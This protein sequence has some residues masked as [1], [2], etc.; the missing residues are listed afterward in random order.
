MSMKGNAEIYEGLRLEDRRIYAS[1]L[2]SSVIEKLPEHKQ[3]SKGTGTFTAKAIPSPNR[4]GSSNSAYP[5]VAAWPGTLNEKTGGTNLIPLRFDQQYGGASGGGFGA[6]PTTLGVFGLQVVPALLI[7]GRYD[8]NVFFTPAIQGVRREDYTTVV[9][10]QL[11]V[12][13]NGRLVSTTVNAGVIGEYFT[14][15]PGL[16][17]VGFNGVVGLDFDNLVRRWVHGASLYFRNFTYYTPAPPSFLTGGSRAYNPL[18]EQDPAGPLTPEDTYIRGFQLQRV[19]TLTNQ[20]TIGGLYPISS[21]TNLIAGYSFAFINFGRQYQSTYAPSLFD[22]VQH[23]GRLGLSERL[24]GRDT[25]TGQY[26]YSHGTFSGGGT[27]DYE[28]H[29]GSVSWTRSYSQSLRSTITGG[30]TLVTQEFSGGATSDLVYTASASLNWTEG[31][32]A[33]TLAY[34]GGVYPSYVSNAGPI[35]SHLVAATGTRR[36][37]DNL[38]G[39]VGVHYSLNKSI[40]DAGGNPGLN[41]ESRTGSAWVNYRVTQSAFLW[42]MYNYGLFSGNYSNPIQVQTFARNEVVLT[43][44]YYWR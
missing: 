20:S 19:N 18:T 33:L 43:L 28:S 40:G 25:V 16:S 26:S 3:P 7:S 21:T 2:Q 32:N 42:L 23:I 35:F 44:A 27:G 30:V 9:H 6:G 29:T 1:G 12:R 37:S 22:N 11:F 8:S 41:L 13:D 17:Y 34:S 10:P 31:L 24:T 36:F 38:T 14:V 5:I 15:H 4:E 39:G